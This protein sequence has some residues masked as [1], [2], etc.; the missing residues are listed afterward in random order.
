MPLLSDGTPSSA[1]SSSWV[2]WVCFERETPQSRITLQLTSEQ[3][4]EA[5]R[6]VAASSSR[7]S[8]PAGRFSGIKVSL[9]GVALQDRVAA[10][11]LK[12][13]IEEWNS[14][15][16][17]ETTTAP[18]QHEGAVMWSENTHMTGGHVNPWCV[19]VCVTVM[20]LT[21]SHGLMTLTDTEDSVDLCSDRLSSLS[22]L[23]FFSD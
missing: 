19:C 12:H 21:E 23:M 5:G 4:R 9:W 11:R 1:P 3:L 2:L 15:R 22:C 14:E 16:L 20:R 18:Q 17:L 10:I 6:L 7:L 8:A 13:F